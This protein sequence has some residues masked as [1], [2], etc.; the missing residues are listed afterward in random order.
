MYRLLVVR[1]YFDFSSSFWNP[2]LIGDIRAL[3]KLQE[4][5]LRIPISFKELSYED[6]HKNGI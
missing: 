1:S 3:E 6:I 5:V 2:Y 4:I